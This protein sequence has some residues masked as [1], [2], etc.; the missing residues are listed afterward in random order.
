MED[1]QIIALLEQR[2]EDAIYAI[3]G[4]YEAYCASIAS[5]ILGDP[6]DVEEVLS[7]CWLRI[8]DSIPPQKPV[9]L[10][11]Y[12]AQ[13]VRNL[14]YDRYRSNNRQKHGGGETALVLDELSE[15]LAGPDQAEDGYIRKELQNAIGQFLNSLSSRDKSIF[16]RRYFYVQQ[17]E[18]IARR[19]GL[20]PAGVRTVLSRTRKKMKS[21]LHKE[22]FSV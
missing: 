16:L 17:I 18:Q 22:G 8:W 21:Y 15:C 1:S 20:S 7:D 5:N 6:Q 12:L 14:A 2:S 3:K 13:I 10:K 19:H 9:H 11:L 4:K